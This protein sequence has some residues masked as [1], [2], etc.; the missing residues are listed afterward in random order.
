M[1]QALNYMGRYRISVEDDVPL[2]PGIVTNTL[3]YVV[4]QGDF[5]L[6]QGQ[7]NGLRNYVHRGKGTL[8]LEGVDT[9]A[10]ASFENFLQMANMQPEPLPQGYRLLT[11]PYFFAAPPPG[12][13]TQGTPKIMVSEGVI[14]STYNYGLLWQGERRGRL[15]SRE[16]IRSATEWGANIITYALDR[17]RMGGKL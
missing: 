17:R 5:E 16:E 2:G 4:G 14:F 8:L 13:E 9:A 6:D 10:E 12:F 11:Q 3:V 1:A 15:A 7:I